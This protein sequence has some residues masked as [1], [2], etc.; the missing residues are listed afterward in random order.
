[1]RLDSS[2]VLCLGENLQEL[3]VR[4]EVESGKGN[5]FCL[6]VLTQPFLH[7]VQQLVALSKVLEETIVSTERDD[8]RQY[9]VSNEVAILDEDIHTPHLQ[10]CANHTAVFSP[11]NR[12]QVVRKWVWLHCNSAREAHKLV[13][14]GILGSLR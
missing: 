2:G 1:M 8:L 5:P 7:L 10:S 12:N 9:T 14:S 13:G 3:I 4:E 6:K 11:E